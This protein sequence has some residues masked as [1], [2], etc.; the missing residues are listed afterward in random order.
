MRWTTVQLAIFKRDGVMF[1]ECLFIPPEVSRLNDEPPRVSA[2][3]GT[4][5]CPLPAF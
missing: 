3:G 1:V 5:R 4:C 2:C